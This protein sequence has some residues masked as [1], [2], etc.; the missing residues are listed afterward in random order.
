MKVLVAHNRY[1]SASP[2]GEDRVVDRERTALEAE[3]HC[4]ELFERFSDDIADWSSLRKASVPARV[5]WSEEARRALVRVL[6]ERR[7]DVVHVH[8]TF[9]LLS[10][11]VLYACRAEGVPVVA[12][13]HNYNLVC[14]SGVLFRDGVV[15][16]DC[17][18]RLP[19]PGVRHGCYRDSV[20]ASLPVAAA[21]V[22][23]RRAWRT[24]VSAYVFISAAQRDIMT[25]D[26]FPP[27][28]SFV[29][30][31]FVPAQAE[32]PGAPEDVVVY[33]G[34]LTATKGLPLLMNA[35]D[36]YARDAGSRPLRLAV[37]GAGP[38][39]GEVAA[40]AAS[41]PSV[42]WRGM[43]NPSDCASLVARAR[44]CIVPSQWEETFGLVVV[45]A[46]AAGVPPV[47]S[48]HGSFPELI[49]DG[50]DGVLFSPGAAAELAEVFVDIERHPERYRKM[51]E[52]GRR[53][54][55][56]RFSRQANIEELLRIYR[57][58]IQN[59]AG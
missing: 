18:G 30:H 17:V 16:H 40:W 12:T 59:P 46:M 57:F 48:A 38:L 27:E 44:A 36:R 1:R 53:T 10:A 31:N 41:R 45:E 56:E 54:Y 43:L 49:T 15:C 51:G 28:R 7:P 26:G 39:E 14:A 23:H 52:A 55:V 20:A 50:E 35:W 4:V 5:V 47:A 9:P 21:L 2:S 34:R 11:S 19:L 42:D 29:K 25:I 6:R 8:N 33:A 13:L 58:A 32:A 24:L 3:G 37:A 22:T